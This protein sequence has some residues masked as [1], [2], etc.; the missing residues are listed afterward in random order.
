V[1][2]LGGGGTADDERPVWEAALAGCRTVLYW[3]FALPV[4]A[5]AE[6]LFWLDRQLAP[7]GSFAIEMWSTLGPADPSALSR[8]DLL[9]VGGGN[10]Y[11]LLDEVRRHGW[12][13]PLGAWVRGGGAYYGGS[14]GA[15][16]A[17]A[18]IDVA[19]QVGDPNEVGLTD[20][21]ALNL[22]GGRDLWPHFTDADIGPARARVGRTGRPVL[23]VPE[24]GGLLVDGGVIRCAGPEPVWALEA[25]VD[26]VLAPGDEIDI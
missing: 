4:A 26:R 16:L 12:L 6:S 20:T 14:A 11:A 7:F 19:G 10:T 18:D 23:G 22:L 8:Y 17:G 5:H 15:V 2:H 3:P 25:G 21:A 24:R 9:F 13:V 1:I